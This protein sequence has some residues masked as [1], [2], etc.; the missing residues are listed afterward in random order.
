MIGK[1]NAQRAGI[2]RAFGLTQVLTVFAN[3]PLKIPSKPLKAFEDPSEPRIKRLGSPMGTE[4]IDDSSQRVR[5][6]GGGKQ[7]LE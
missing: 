6:G 4:S 3:F 2:D 1:N 7:E 5:L